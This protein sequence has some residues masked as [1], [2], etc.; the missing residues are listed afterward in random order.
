[1]DKMKPF[2]SY[3]KRFY[4]V[5]NT[6][7][8]LTRRQRQLINEPYLSAVI[9][10]LSDTNIELSEHAQTLLLEAVE[11]LSRLDAYLKDKVISFPMLLLRTEALSSS[12]IEHYSASNKNVALAQIERKHTTEAVIIKSNLESLIQGVSEKNNL[13]IDKIIHL[14]QMLID[15]KGITLRNRINWIGTP[16]SIPHEASYVPPHPEYL[17]L[18]MTQFIAFCQ[19]NDVHPLVQAAFAHAY[20][21]IIHPFEDGNGRV[22]RI[23][24]QM[25]LKEKLFLEHLYVPLSVGLVKDQTR[26]VE[27]LNDFKLGQYESMVILV[28]EHALALLP[29]IYGTLE[30]LISLK[31][32]WQEKLNLRQDALAWQLL[33]DIISQPVIDVKYIKDK[34]HANDQAVRN[35]IDA[36]ISVD[37]LSPIGN[38]KRNVAYECKEVLALL[39]QFL[40]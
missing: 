39:D 9:M 22:G 8:Y 15:N 5:D 34:Y 6:F 38:H 23:I 26:Y 28:L 21:E 36:L 25:I 19:R 12:Q 18:Y 33:D 1:M 4:R 30:Q 29:N 17:N 16:N 31:Q 27:A 14:N 32:S 40:I 10:D 13:D 3:E 37:I 35:N 7:Q 2:V 11:G 20:F 24:I